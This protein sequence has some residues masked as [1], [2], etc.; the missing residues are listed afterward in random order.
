MLKK[1]ALLWF[2]L[3]CLALS[4]LTANA[5]LPHGKSGTTPPV[6]QTLPQISSGTDVVG[7]TLG[8]TAGTYSGS[9]ATLTYKW[10]VIDSGTSLGT[11][12]TLLLT[13]A[14]VTA[15]SGSTD[16]ACGRI[17][18]DEKATNSAGNVTVNSM[19]VGPVQPANPPQYSFMAICSSGCGSG[20]VTVGGVTVTSITSRSATNVQGIV[21]AT[22]PFPTSSNV[23][24]SGGTVTTAGFGALNPSTTL[25]TYPAHYLQ[26]GHAIAP[27]Y[28]IPP[29][30]PTATG[31]HV[32]FFDGVSGSNGNSGHSGSP[33]KDPNQICESSTGQ[34]PLFPGTI[35]P[36]DT[37]LIKGAGQTYSPAINFNCVSQ[38]STSTGAVNGTPLWT[39]IESDPASATP[40]VL[41]SI[42]FNTGGAGFIFKNFGM[43]NNGVA[44]GT[45]VNGSFISILGSSAA[46]AY[47][48]VFEQINGSSWMGHSGDP[49]NP[50]LYPTTGGH[51]D[52]TIQTA[53]PYAGN[54]PINGAEYIP[55]FPAS[56]STGTPT[57]LLF[58][59]NGMPSLGTNIVADVN[60]VW[61]AGYYGQQAVTGE[62]TGIPPGTKLVDYNGIAGVT[63]E[64][65][66]ASPSSLPV[67]PVLGEGYYINSTSGT[68]P[69][70]FYYGCQEPTVTLCPSGTSLVWA[71]QGQAYMTLAH[72]DPVTDAGT[73]CPSAIYHNPLGGTS[74][75]TPFVGCDPLVTFL[76][77][78]GCLSGT[79]PVWNGV[80]RN[81]TAENIAFTYDMVVLP[82]G[83]WNHLDWVYAWTGATIKGEIGTNHLDPTAKNDVVGTYAI[84]I[85]DS[86]FRNTQV[87]LGYGFVHDSVFYNNKSKYMAVDAIELFA[88]HRVIA[89]N[90]YMSDFSFA[91]AHPDLIQL[92]YGGPPTTEDAVYYGT[93]MVDN[94]GYSST[95]NT[96]PFQDFTQPISDVTDGVWS[97]IYLVNNI[98]NSSL[99]PVAQAGLYNVMAQNDI[100]SDLTA[101][102]S[103]GQSGSGTKSALYQLQPQFSLMENNVS[104]AFA[105]RATNSSNQSQPWFTATGT[106][107]GGSVGTLTVGGIPVQAIL[108]WNNTTVT[109]TVPGTYGVLTPSTANVLVNGSA[110]SG[111]T[112][113]TI[114]TNCSAGQLTQAGNVTLP[115]IDFAS[116][117]LIIGG[118]NVCGGL[119]NAAGL[120]NNYAASGPVTGVSMWT[121]N[122]WRTEIG[123]PNSPFM[124]YHPLAPTGVPNAFLGSSPCIQ[125]EFDVGA[126]GAPSGAAGWMNLRPNPSFVPAPITNL[127]ATEQNL[128]GLPTSGGSAGDQYMVIQSGGIFSTVFQVPIIFPIGVYTLV[129][130]AQTTMSRWGAKLGFTLT[131][132]GSAFGTPGTVTVGGVAAASITSWTTSTIVGIAADNISNTTA[133][134]SPSGGGTIT[135]TTTVTNLAA[136]NVAS[137]QPPIIAAGTPLGINGPPATHGRLPVTNP[138]NVGAY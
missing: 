132:S 78:G 97:N 110:P 113:S 55:F 32:W 73:G 4:P 121:A 25:P 28:D 90:N 3:V 93:S 64:G 1:I 137:Y 80:T 5:W 70:H 61:P 23:L 68:N 63:Y 49:W 65:T 12:T 9:P 115:G 20:A 21:P 6:N 84:S 38:Y 66:I 94:E 117:A 50:S 81:I 30:A 10:H 85:K 19:F 104:N 7:D 41:A 51:A 108:S 53:S 76:G 125:N 114:L 59:G 14:M 135:P 15:C 134:V 33:F 127:I 79:A 67:T 77:T 82:A 71:D 42:N 62:N 57:H 86:S 46:P 43:E 36:G 34:G 102:T 2:A 31:T 83:W 92:G 58:V 95:D 40:A 39:W 136:S 129:N 122:D 131:S 96:N 74:N 128:T 111:V 11:G 130:P 101:S 106:G 18:V 54:S 91:L 109:G 116:G 16:P 69:S 35:L 88:D 75:G 124:E 118:G 133:V 47:D 126:C 44:S 29:T 37:I 99:A 72:C 105:V 120:T 112:N 17:Q 89:A 98:N 107:F 103:F 52:G 13:T 60:Y 56:A 45:G 8:L 24:V 100:F 27:G 138:P 48:L 22:A 26:N 87:A 119:S 123:S